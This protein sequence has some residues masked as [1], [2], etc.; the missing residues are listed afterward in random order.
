M[1]AHIGLY[2]AATEGFNNKQS[3]AKALSE[4]AV[5][6]SDSTEEE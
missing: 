1:I 5:A 6:T 4:E 2:K 3:V